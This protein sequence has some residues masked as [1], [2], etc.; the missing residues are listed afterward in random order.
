[1]SMKSPEMFIYNHELQQ[2]RIKR[3]GGLRTFTALK[4]Y[5][6]EFFITGVKRY[7][8]SLF[9]ISWERKNVGKYVGK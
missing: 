5:Y 7:L 8:L 3:L 9:N 6:Y 4:T 2:M 1:M